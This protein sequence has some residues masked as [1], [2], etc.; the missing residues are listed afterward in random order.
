MKRSL[1]IGVLA[2]GLAACAPNMSP[3]APVVGGGAVAVADPA[4]EGRASLSATWGEQS[5]VEFSAG[6]LDAYGVVL[7][8]SGDGLRVNAPTWCTVPKDSRD[9]LCTVPQLPAGKNFVLPMRGSRLSIVATYKRASGN[10][11]RS[12]VHQ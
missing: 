4:D 12:Q 1:V 11:Y 9:I 2:L 8:V 7:R 3:V 5:R 6:N 10:T